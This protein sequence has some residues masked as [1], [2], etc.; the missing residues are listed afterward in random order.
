VQEQRRQQ[1]LNV[2]VVLLTSFTLI[3]VSVDAYNF[4]REEG[5]LIE[6]RSNRVELLVEA[7]ALMV[8]AVSF[9]IYV[10]MRRR[11]D[12]GRAEFRRLQLARR[13]EQR[14]QDH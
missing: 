14:G 8:L 7:V 4:V 1:L 12:Q 6:D 10:A 2:I 13:P 9:A 5:T 3:S 11:A